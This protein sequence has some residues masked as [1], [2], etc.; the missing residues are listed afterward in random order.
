M[1]NI[2]RRNL[3]T[4]LDDPL[5]SMDDLFR[6]FFVRPVEYQS[7]PH[8]SVDVR[9]DDKN[10]TVHA[11]LPG[12]KKEDV[13]VQIEGSVIHISAESRHDKEE[14]QGEKL[15]RSER[16]IGRVSR[17]FTLATD[18]DESAATA[19]FENGVLELVLPKKAPSDQRHKLLIK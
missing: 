13:D 19:K 1:A 3:D 2:V 6:G 17:S 4:L 11:D 16:Y 5:R 10:Y 9:E 8:I 18:V 14:K 15:I 12:V 7:G